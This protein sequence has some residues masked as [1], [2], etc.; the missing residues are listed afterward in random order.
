M[1]GAGC[2]R[3][4]PEAAAPQAL[5]WSEEACVWRTNA[6]EYRDLQLAAYFNE[7]GSGS[8]WPLYGLLLVYPLTSMAQ[9][10]CSGLVQ[11]MLSQHAFLGAAVL[12][13]FSLLPMALVFGS[14][15]FRAFALFGP[16][17]ALRSLKSLKEAR[18]RAE[19]TE[20]EA[21]AAQAAQGPQIF[22][23][24]EGRLRF[25]AEYRAFVMISTCVVILAV[26]FA[27]LY[28]REHAKTETFGYAL[29]DLGTGCIVVATAV[30]VRSRRAP[31]RT[32]W[33]LRVVSVLRKLWPAL[34]LGA[35][36]GALLWQLDYHVPVSEYGVHWNFFFTV[37]I[38]AL[39]SSLLELTAMQ[40][41]LAGSSVAMAYQLFLSMGGNDFL[42]LAPRL[43]LFSANREGILGC[44]GYLSLHWLGIGLGSLLRDR[45]VSA[46]LTVLRLL[47]ISFSGGLLT[48]LLSLAGIA[49]SRRLCNLPYVLHILSLNAWVLAWLAFADLAAEHPR[50]PLSLTLAAVSESMLAVFLFANLLT[51]V[52]NLTMQPLLLPQAAAFLALACYYLSW[53]VP[54]ALLRSK[55]RKLKCW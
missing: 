38:I 5:L 11:R 51:G 52:V 39:V 4:G 18:G 44:L 47:A 21:Q 24:A 41:V 1:G 50:P 16:Q 30:S 34:A 17:L 53:S 45:S 49:V 10:S 36:R 9:Q 33:A 46:R 42:L 35:L 31:E 54:C 22:S 12:D 15:S 23:E 27:A 43:T 8:A 14:A 28:P 29:M 19:R 2:P 32:L 7:F 26:D 20:A 3:L 48:Y 6:T 40:S 13:A 37:A 55:G 25:L